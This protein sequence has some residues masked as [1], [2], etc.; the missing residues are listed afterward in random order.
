VIFAGLA[1]A[2]FVFEAGR[3]ERSGMVV[4]ASNRLVL[5]AS[6]Q[7]ADLAAEG[8]EFLRSGDLTIAIPDP[9]LA[10]AG[11]YARD[12]LIAQ[13]LWSDLQGR[14]APTLDVRAALAAVTSGSTD[15]AI[16]YQT[17]ATTEDGIAVLPGVDLSGHEPIV[18][19][20]VVISGASQG[21][22]AQG[23]LEFLAGPDGQTVFSRYGFL[24]GPQ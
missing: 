8:P 19:P 21:A 17:D 1:P 5:V 10:P 3:A 16:V 14:V 9:G 4:L 13:G 12:A 6:D 24:A 18:Y 15:F 20:A 22:A 2:E 23:F 11:A 7:N